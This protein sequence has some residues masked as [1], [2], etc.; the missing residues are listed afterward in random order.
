M[1]TLAFF[2]VFHPRR[3]GIADYS[4]DL[5]AALSRHLDITCYV[6]EGYE[7]DR[8][9][10]FARVQPHTTFRGREDV[11]LF[12]IGNSTELAFQLEHLIRHGGVATLHDAC[13]LDLTY[14]YFRAHRWRFAVEVFRSVDPAARRRLLPRTLN[15]AR[16]LHHAFATYEQHP[17]KRRLFP[18][19]RFV[20]RHADRLVVHSDYLRDYARQ[21]TPR[22]PV[23]VVRLGVRPVVL[24]S[25]AASRRRLA[26]Q[27]GVAVGPAT[28]VFLSFGALQAHKRIAAVLRAFQAFRAEHADAVYVL[29]GPRDST[30][31]LEAEIRAHGAAD[32]VKIIDTY[33]PMEMV[34][35]LIQAADLT[36]NLRWPSLGST[37]STL[38]KIFAVGR[39]SVITRADSFRD[40][41]EELVFAVPPPPGDGEWR[42]CL[43]AMR[44]A[45]DDPDRL[46]AMGER[47]RAYVA[48]HCSWERVAESYRKILAAT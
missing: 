37:S 12:Q 26:E 45:A 2:S 16:W 1:R 39:P 25:R 6:E 36:F 27:L 9:C 47:A 43:E 28:L 44:T 18:F 7:P 38:H 14:P 21:L 4:D 10:E 20:L 35:E 48:E 34:N 32:R 17:D 46:A 23:N 19:S 24:G 13:Q 33:L 29:V 42:G 30:Y 3:M 11:A 31:D 41:P 15:P 5:V 22:L 8:V 40:Y